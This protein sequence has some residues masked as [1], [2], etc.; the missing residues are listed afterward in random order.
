MCG[1]IQVAG[2]ILVRLIMRAPIGSGEGGPNGAPSFVA[3]A[4]PIGQFTWFFWAAGLPDL[5]VTL[6]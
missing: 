5:P 3:G 2:L 1:R 4:E 6:H